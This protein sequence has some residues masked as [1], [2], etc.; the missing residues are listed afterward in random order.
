MGELNPKEA[1]PRRVFDSDFK[2]DA[3][4]LVDLKSFH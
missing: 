1:T 3:V 4:K 2:S